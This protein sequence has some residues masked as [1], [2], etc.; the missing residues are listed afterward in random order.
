MIISTSDRAAAIDAWGRCFTDY[1][2]PSEI[3]IV[4]AP[5]ASQSAPA[6]APSKSHKKKDI[7]A[8]AALAKAEKKAS[9]Q[10]QP[11]AKTKAINKQKL[12]QYKNDECHI[13]EKPSLKIN[14]SNTN[15]STNKEIAASSNPNGRALKKMKTVPL[16]P[17]SS[18]SISEDMTW[19]RSPRQ[20]NDQQHGHR[21]PSTQHQQQ[22]K[23]RQ[24]HSVQN[25]HQKQY[26]QQHH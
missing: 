15:T 22:Q 6:A 10:S 14:T 5:P 24:Q 1:C 26:Q 9:N 23:L 25:Q 18:S 3:Y 2:G 12:A 4:E 21:P 17:P 16:V 20:H 11:P 13:D 19:K 8:A 7:A